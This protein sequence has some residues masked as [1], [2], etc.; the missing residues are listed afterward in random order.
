MRDRARDF[1]EMGEAAAR[2]LAADARVDPASLAAR[3]V[4]MRTHRGVASRADFGAELRVAAS[5]LA[6]ARLTSLQ[7]R[8]PPDLVFTTAGV[9]CSIEVGRLRRTGGDAAADDR[10][11]A[12]RAAGVLA[13]V[14]TGADARREIGHV[15]AVVRRKLDRAAQLGDVGAGPAAALVLVSDSDRLIDDHVLRVG[16]ADALAAGAPRSCGLVVVRDMT[17]RPIAGARPWGAVFRIGHR[18][19]AALADAVAA[20]WPG[21]EWIDAAS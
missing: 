10:S 11:E 2:A 12:A 9:E 14:A 7:F 19:D 20:G 18:V 13:V 6:D 3:V 4:Q 8:D 16:V 5:L 15:A 21:A 17:S 1:G